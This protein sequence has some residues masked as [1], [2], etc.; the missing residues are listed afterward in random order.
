MDVL[1][2]K[3]EVLHAEDLVK[4]CGER[5]FEGNRSY[6]DFIDAAKG[7]EL[8]SEAGNVEGEEGGAGEGKAEVQPAMA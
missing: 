8:P 7:G 3:E 4:I 6:Q 5:P 1:L 2:L